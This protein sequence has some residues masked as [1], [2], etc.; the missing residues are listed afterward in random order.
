MLFF[1][2]FWFTDSLSLAHLK[3]CCRQSSFKNGNLI[4]TLQTWVC[5]L[6]SALPLSLRTCLAALVTSPAERLLLLTA[7]CW[8]KPGSGA[9]DP[10][11]TEIHAKDIK[12]GADA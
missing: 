6:H 3:K 9:P 7:F 10:H 4:A 11:L 1:A 5:I 12:F 8:T 2:W